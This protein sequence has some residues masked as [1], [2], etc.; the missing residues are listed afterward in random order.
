MGIQWLKFTHNVC[1]MY[2]LKVRKDEH[3]TNFRK[4]YRNTRIREGVKLPRWLVIL[5]FSRRA[6]NKA[7]PSA[8][9]ISFFPSWGMENSMNKARVFATDQFIPVIFAGNI[10]TSCV[11]L[12]CGYCLSLG[13]YVNNRRPQM[14][15]VAI[16]YR[17]V[18]M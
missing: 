18:V 5:D 17:L 14:K 10:M 16:V 13:S 7:P 4:N 12:A 8:S 9:D 11:M 1:I 6:K 3:D 15:R 2:K